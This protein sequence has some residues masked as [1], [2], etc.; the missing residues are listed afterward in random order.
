MRFRSL[1]CLESLL[2]LA[3]E[4]PLSSNIRLRG[5]WVR[6]T[7]LV[8]ANFLE[9]VIDIYNNLLCLWSQSPSLCI[10]MNTRENV[11][12][13]HD[14]HMNKWWILLKCTLALIAYNW[15]GN[16]SPL[17]S[18]HKTPFFNEGL[19]STRTYYCTNVT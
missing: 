19:N 10:F 14:I 9:I 6:Y 3:H 17:L 12:C 4:A 8:V 15:L 5:P 2:M 13:S 16:T 11:V 1:L 18:M 7:K